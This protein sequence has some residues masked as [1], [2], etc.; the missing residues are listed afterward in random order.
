MK[1]DDRL[2]IPVSRDF[3]RRVARVARLR[4]QGTAASYSR[5]AIEH[6]LLRDE[7]EVARIVQLTGGD[8]TWRNR[9]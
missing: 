3:K 4:G 9:P 1:S 2:D 6:R 8:V 7:E 5:E